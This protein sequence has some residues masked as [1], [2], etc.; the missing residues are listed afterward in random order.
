MKSKHQIIPLLFLSACMLLSCSHNKLKTNEK[1]LKEQILRTENEKELELMAA[2]EKALAD[3]LTRLPQGFRFNENRSVDYGHPPLVID[4]AGNLQNKK[5]LRLSD[6]ASTIK[7]IRLEPL[8]DS[9]L[10]CEMKYKYCLMDNF[11]VAIN[12]NGIHLFTK[13]GKYIRTVV[14]N[15]YTGV[16]ITPDRIK[17]RFNMTFHGGSTSAWAHGNNLYYTYSN[18]LTGQRCIMEYDC[19]KQQLLSTKFD[20]E[21]PK[22]ITGLGKVYI[23]LNHGREVP[24]NTNKNAN[25]MWSADHDFLYEGM[26]DFSPDKNTYV[27]PLGGHYMLGI[28]SNKG[29]TLTKFTMYEQLKNY[30][31]SL[32]RGTDYGTRYQIRGKLFFRNDFNDTLFQVIPP[33]QLLPMYV[34]KLDNYKVTKQQGMDPNFDLTGKIIP[35][36]TA[37]TK[38]YIF[39]TFTKDNYDCPANRQNKKVKIYYALF[40]KT[41]RQLYIDNGDPYNYSPN[42]LENNIDGGMPVWPK[43]Y[44]IGNNGE[45][46]V[47]L[48][49]NEMKRHIDSELFS[50]STAPIDKKNQLKQYVQMLSD[51]DDILMIVE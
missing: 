3:T 48:K 8:P 47:S 13:E 10:Q 7:Y 5:K 11:I 2:R 33:N 16:E 29:D 41:N 23:D 46:L 38:N 51:K 45:I 25:G 39:I 17:M 36:S 27:K 4:I 49:G 21:N 24:M 12:Y 19:T 14:K 32:V 34:I 44:M 50:K 6:V 28:F 43:S 37:E 31:K 9:S 30:T 22:K 42:L 35:G 26:G 15:E 18:S 20:P 1:V 40:L